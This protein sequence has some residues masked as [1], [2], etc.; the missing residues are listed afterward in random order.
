M[1]LV[2]AI[3]LPVALVDIF[4]NTSGTAPT[5]VVGVVSAFDIRGT[6]D[7]TMPFSGHNCQNK[8]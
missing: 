1:S 3:R 2:S 4:I 7:S 5:Q 8:L 6:K